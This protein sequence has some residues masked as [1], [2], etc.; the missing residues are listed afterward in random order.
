MF[1]VHAASISEICH[2]IMRKNQ[3]RDNESRPRI[4][5]GGGGRMLCRSGKTT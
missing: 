3:R 1:F 2:L 4:E 5:S